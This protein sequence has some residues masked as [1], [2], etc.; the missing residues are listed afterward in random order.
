V[1]ER[2]PRRGY[3][4]YDETKPFFMTSEF[5]TLVAAAAGVLIAAAMVDELDARRAW[6]YVTILASAYMVSRGLAKAGTRHRD[7]D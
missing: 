1:D 6:L 7:Y 4:G 5:L 3:G 2:G